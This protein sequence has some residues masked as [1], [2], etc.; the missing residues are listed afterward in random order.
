MAFKSLATVL[1]VAASVIA[2]PA[3]LEERATCSR[4]TIINTRGTG[5][6]Q[7]QS[8]GFT[9]M[10]SNVQRQLSGGTIV[11]PSLSQTI[12]VGRSSPS[13]STTRMLPP[14]F[15]QMMLRLR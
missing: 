5:E 10:N 3:A 15:S 12:N 11:S 9:T 4:Y 13:N 7:G 2:A 14:V 1:M 6:P 8:S